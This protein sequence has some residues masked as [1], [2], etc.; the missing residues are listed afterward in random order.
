MTIF[1]NR[2]LLLLS[3]FMSM[4]FVPAWAAAEVVGIPAVVPYD[5]SANIRQAIK[6]E[7]KLGERLVKYLTKYAKKTVAVSTTPK[8]GQYLNM[9]ITNVYAKGGGLY[10]G[11]K[12]M[13]VK[14]TLMKNGK[15]GPSFRAKRIT[16]RGAR[17]CSSAAA[18]A[19]AIGK[20]ISV[21]LKNP[22]DGASLGDAK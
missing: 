4:T 10:S 5:E 11:A 9:R 2:Y 3:V 7:C 15:A 16:T 17:A 13:E 22:V 6:D 20:D 14:G 18:C 19:K 1:K 8:K 12:W 21:W